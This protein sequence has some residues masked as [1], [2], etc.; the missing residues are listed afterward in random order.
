MTHLDGQALWTSPKTSLQADT[1][2]CEGGRLNEGRSTLLLIHVQLGQWLERVLRG[3]LGLV[4]SKI[5]ARWWSQWDFPFFFA[6]LLHYPFLSVLDHSIGIVNTIAVWIRAVQ[7]VL[8][9]NISSCWTSHLWSSWNS[10]TWALIQL[11]TAD[12]PPRAEVA[13]WP[14]QLVRL[15]PHLRPH[16]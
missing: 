12:G 5:P 7:F 4:S 14:P 16:H 10:N 3:D 8:G 15:W 1:L 13:I 6:F 2:C 9:T 11:L